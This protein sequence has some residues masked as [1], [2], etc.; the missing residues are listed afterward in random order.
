MFGSFG[1]C[2]ECLLKLYVAEGQGGV[3]RLT[4]DDK[5]VILGYVQ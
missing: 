4:R 3:A 1:N 5:D 2:R